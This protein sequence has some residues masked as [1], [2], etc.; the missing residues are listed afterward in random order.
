MRIRTGHVCGEV[1]IQELI[2]ERGTIRCVAKG[3]GA[4]SKGLVGPRPI[5]REFGL[6]HLFASEPAFAPWRIV[7]A[8]LYSQTQSPT[9]KLGR[10]GAK[11]PK[12]LSFAVPHG[13]KFRRVHLAI[14]IVGAPLFVGVLTPSR[15]MRGGRRPSGS[16]IFPSTM[17]ECLGSGT[18]SDE[19]SRSRKS[20]A[21]LHR[22]LFFIFQQ[23]TPPYI[24]YLKTVIVSTMNARRY[25]SLLF[26][27]SNESTHNLHV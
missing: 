19:H 14:N 26:P 6:D 25:L 7:E 15:S 11:R 23:G 21:L 13:K 20:S 3:A 16:P 17:N 10:P 2:P 22:S 5:K 4:D 24:V 1:N 18:S 8:V 12:G 9:T 27:Q